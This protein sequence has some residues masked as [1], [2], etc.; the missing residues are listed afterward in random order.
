M[1]LVL[2]GVNHK[3]CPLAIREKFFL[4]PTEKELLFSELRNDPAVA[5]VF[6]LSTC[7]RT[8][9]YVDLLN[10]KVSSIFQRF[11]AVKR[12]PL[13]DNL[14][15]FFYVIHEQLAVVHLLRVATGLDSL[16]LGEK[17]ILGQVKDAFNFARGEKMLHRS[18]NILSNIVVE[19]GK[20]IRRETDIDF[21]GLS[22]SWAAV[23]KAQESFGSL[24]GK[25]VL[26]MGSGKMGDLAARQL[27]KKGVG[28]VYI[29]NRT[30]DKAEHVAEGC[31]GTAVPFWQ[32]KDIL[33]KVDVC[34][35]ATGA[36]HYVVTKDLMEEVMS[37]RKGQRI[38]IVDIAVPRN[39]DPLVTCV[40]GV[41]LSVVDDLSQMVQSSMNKRLTAVERA[42]EIIR[43]KTDEFYR[44]QDKAAVFELLHA[45]VA[46]EKVQS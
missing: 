19:T 13:E 42:E 28:N 18:F 24:A 2:I 15:R 9:I 40:P 6:I 22:I 20:K 29:M 30:H 5:G 39:I 4:Q 34:L 12:L 43:M 32:L 11:F 33:V 35:C 8:E 27:V 37:C 23:A 14:E 26:I 16:I 36:P 17:Q 10:N 21:G 7:N 46:G 41:S 1:S 3:T 45:A 38:S 44:I 31:C 25:D